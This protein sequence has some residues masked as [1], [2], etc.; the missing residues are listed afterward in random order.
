M[1]E[2]PT[3]IKSVFQDRLQRIRERFKGFFPFV[4]GMLATLPGAFSL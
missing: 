3:S 2:Q 1:N 4:S